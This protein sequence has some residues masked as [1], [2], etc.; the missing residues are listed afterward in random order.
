MPLIDDKPRILAALRAIP[1]VIDALPV[2][3]KDWAALPCI[4]VVKSGEAAA[5]FRDDEE[6]LTD[7]EYYIRVFTNTE[8][9]RAII[10]SAAHDAMQALGYRRTFAWE[11]DTAE[12][13]QMVLRYRQKFTTHEI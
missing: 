5:D 9:E 7:V 2:W 4:V 1:G 12:A 3:P 6:Y 13:R 10:S 8:T 11:D